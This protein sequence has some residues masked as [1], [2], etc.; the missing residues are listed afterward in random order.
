MNEIKKLLPYLIV[1][2]L[3][4]FGP[5]A[6]F[7][8]SYLVRGSFAFAFHPFVLLFFIYP[9]VCFTASL[10]YGLLNRFTPN[11]WLFPVS[12]SVLISISM[13]I[14]FGFYSLIFYGLFYIIMVLGGYA[15]GYEISRRFKRTKHD[16]RKG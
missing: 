5:T 3:T 14:F 2:I 12:V 1:F 6:L 10:V 8:I 7:H 15:F 11:K 16:V 9:F 4:F 13:T